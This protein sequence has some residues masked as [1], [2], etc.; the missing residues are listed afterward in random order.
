MS[1]SM[2][3]E[4]LSTGLALVPIPLGSKGP[5]YSGWAKP[6]GAM[7]DLSRL[8]YGTADQW[9]FGLHHLKSGT[10][11][12]DID[13]INSARDTFRSHRLDLD[14]Y[15][16][17]DLGIYSGNPG[18][19]KL[20]YRLPPF[21]AYLPSVKIKQPD[22]TRMALELR[23]A[24]QDGTTSL[25]DVLPP[26]I[27]PDTLCSYQWV[28]GGPGDIQVLPYEIL[29]MWQGI[30]D[31][32]ERERQEQARPVMH[33]DA[34]TYQKIADAL[35][36][37]DPD[38]ERDKWLEVGFA[39]HDALG[40]D[41]EQL[42]HD[43]SERG[44]KYAGEQDVRAVWASIEHEPNGVTARTLY[45]YAKQGGWRPVPTFA[46]IMDSF[47]E[48]EKK[49]E[50]VE[51]SV[52][53][54]PRGRKLAAELIAEIDAIGPMSD[55][56]P[57]QLAHV[58]TIL[59]RSAQLKNPA[60]YLPIQDR[61]K[62][63]M[64][65]SHRRM[66][67]HMRFIRQGAE[68]AIQAAAGVLAFA[69]VNAMGQPKDH[70]EN[71]TAICDHLGIQIR[72]D[73]MSHET[74]IYDPT[75]AAW[76]PDEKNNLQRSRIR[77]LCVEQSMPYARSDEHIN[78]LGCRASYHPL[79][80]Y[81]ESTQWDG[82]N[83]F[84][85]VADTVKTK[86][87]WLWELTLKRWALSACAAA[88]ELTERRPPRGV[89][90]MT[91]LQNT[92][93]TSWFRYLTPKGMFGEGIHLDP[94]NKDSVKLATKKAIVELGELDATFG[95]TD[96]ARLKAHLSSPYDEIRLPYA[97]S[98]SKWPRRTVYCGTVNEPDFL[99]DRTG[100]TRFWT[101]EVTSIDLDTMEQLVNQGSLCQF[102][103]QVDD[104]LS[105]GER[106]WMSRDEI[107][108]IEK[109]N[110][111]YIGRNV[112]EDLLLDAYAWPHGKDGLWTDVIGDLSY[113]QA[114]PVNPMR[115]TDIAKSV[116]L[117]LGRKGTAAGKELKD[118]LRR[119]TG[120]AGMVR[121][122][123]ETWDPITKKRAEVG[124]LG[125]WYWM[126]YPMTQLPVA[127]VITPNFGIVQQPTQL[128]ETK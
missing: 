27:H 123:V 10:C 83:W 93:K 38:V 105:K 103:A 29:A 59:A 108:A 5:R 17:K 106:W 52:K 41:G 20:I 116:G 56:N 19:A 45:Y 65:W 107:V 99:V 7:T 109:N 63:E 79:E 30:L 35:N 36:F 90:V 73:R 4:C 121:K 100:N 23:C 85:L 37:V 18:H 72:H 86:N 120:Q 11:A 46:E 8:T 112:Y 21:L 69:H 96:L 60:D 3:Q 39:I 57:D 71:L 125:R 113:D 15:L 47:S 76:L 81:L 58:Q 126:P 95:K 43:W 14:T 49:T 110:E 114:S 61:I 55:T 101:N 118:A 115:L 62:A 48:E 12:I 6:E 68:K 51:D 117:D 24:N 32:R 98:E 87:K 31:E 2:I 16:K 66:E 28:N 40:P 89:L 74:E 84:G 42:F 13:H 34:L 128:E 70:S 91:A 119:L 102:W 26:S 22:N 80:D 44:V 124:E 127:K 122:R 78:T 104:W 92:G 75:I 88:R 94:R 25:Q 97:R 53:I 111:L 54:T 82:R 33:A 77:D 67:Q 64:G 50:P 9:N 1:L